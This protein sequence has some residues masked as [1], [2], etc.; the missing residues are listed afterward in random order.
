M[1]NGKLKSML[2]VTRESSNLS[3]TH[4]LNLFTELNHLNWRKFLAQLP[5]RS[6][7]FASVVCSVIENHL[8][9][10]KKKK[11]Q[12][13]AKWIVFYVQ[14]S[15]HCPPQHTIQWQE[16]LKASSFFLLCLGGRGKYS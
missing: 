16:N 9:K 12:T 6:R 11:R 1:E 2:S 4:A 15:L 8:S 14:F 10:N 5:L 3:L 13:N 7:L